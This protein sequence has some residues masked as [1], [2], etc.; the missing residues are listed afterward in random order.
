VV[1]VEMIRLDIMSNE[2]INKSVVF[3]VVLGSSCE[4]EKMRVE[5]RG[6]KS[7]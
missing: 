5:L 3:I 6:V 7:E 2:F 4:D 1:V